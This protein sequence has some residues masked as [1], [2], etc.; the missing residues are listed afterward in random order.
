M[1]LFNRKNKE[2]VVPVDTYLRLGEHLKQKEINNNLLRRDVEVLL[3]CVID[4][5]KIRRSTISRTNG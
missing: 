2:I 1:G 4:G 5:K 3:D